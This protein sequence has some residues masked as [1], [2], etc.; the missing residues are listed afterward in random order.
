MNLKKTLN[1]SIKS[2][3][4]ILKL[5]IP[6]YILA[7]I[8]FYYNTL[9]YVSFLVEPFTSILGL[10]KEAALSII[11]GMFLNLYA[12]VAFA[13]P[14]DMSPQQWTVLAVFLGICHSL[15]VE[16][17]IMKKIGLSNT[18]SYLLRFF[19]G[20][21]VAYLTTFIPASYF[22]SNINIEA[23]E[24]KSYDSLI[25]LLQISAYNAFILSLKIIALITALIFIMD[26]IKT[27]DF[28]QKSGKNISKS[29][30][31]LVGVFLGITYGA[32]ILIEEAKGTSL[33]KKDIFFIGTFLMICHA[34]IE[35]TLLFVI[36][37]ADFTIIIAIR[38]VAA[39]IIS[40]AMLY[41]FDKKYSK[42][43][44]QSI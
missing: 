13:A 1:S 7:E 8:L 25:S 43:T 6:I 34:I 32:G 17:V 11:S 15:V 19:A 3:W 39:I 16:S 44:K 18:Y 33:S 10:P 22:M 21:I 5:V 38:T 24:E 36:F 9:A 23:F 20:L 31:I 35:D 12:A 40:Y 2:I 30:S 41:F 37:G 4:I 42:T 27:R 14:L 29:F 28:I 26:F